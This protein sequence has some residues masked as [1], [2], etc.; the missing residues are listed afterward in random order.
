VTSPGSAS[1]GSGPR[2]V[3]SQNGGFYPKSGPI[4]F[5]VPIIAFVAAIISGSLTILDYVHVITGG[6][7]TG[8]D[9]FMGIFGR[10]VMMKISP[11]SRIEV[12]KR[13]TPTMFFLM[14]SIAAVATT[15][16]YVLANKTGLW[17]PSSPYITATIVVVL[18]LL[19]Q[20]F[21]ILLPNELR[22]FREIR[23]ERPDTDK[24]VK[25]S[26]RNL[27]VSGSKAIFQIIIIYIMANLTI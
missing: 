17:N 9:L 19:V 25:L 15:A 13:L 22:V 21:G 2:S 7:W 23:K 8:I 12:A 26:L 16:G 20:G 4:L 24:I 5:S 10:T 1:T 11:L 14:P 6:M 18:I 3:A 27:N